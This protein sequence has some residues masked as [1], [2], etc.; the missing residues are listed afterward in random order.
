MLTAKARIYLYTEISLF[1]KMM[2]YYGFGLL[3]NNDLPTNALM[4]MKPLQQR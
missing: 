3:W 4:K 1:F 2:T